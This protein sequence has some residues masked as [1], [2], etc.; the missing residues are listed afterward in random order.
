MCLAQVFIASIFK[1][2]FSTATLKRVTTKCNEFLNNE[3]FRI[4][5]TGSSYPGLASS[6]EEEWL[7]T[8]SL[9]K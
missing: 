2:L 9:R 1:I 8:S 5:T 6:G 3:G 4:T 7:I